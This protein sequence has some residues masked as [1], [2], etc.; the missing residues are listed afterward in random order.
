MHSFS[1]HETPQFLAGPSGNIEMITTMP[2]ESKAR[3]VSVI[4]CH[5]HPLFGGTMQNKVVTTLARTFHAMGMSTVRFNFR[6]VG[7]SAGVHDHGHGETEDVL[8]IV[9]W[10]KQNRPHHTLWLAGFSFGGFVAASA[11]SRGVAAQLI[12]IAPMVS[13]F[14]EVNLP[15]IT[16]P[17]LLVQGEKDE[18]ISP[19]A[20]YAWVDTLNP[21]P[22]LVRIPGAG[23]FFHGQLAELQRCITASLN[24]NNSHLD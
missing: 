11:A 20:V 9:D 1:S 7:Q 12:T 23:H 16:C 18:V 24:E 15:V 8:A 5:P 21:K 17:W 10:I 4:I 2:E 19:E 6:G 13:R 22:T 3:P 14:L